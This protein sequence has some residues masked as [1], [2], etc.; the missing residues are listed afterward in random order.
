MVLIP[1]DAP[2]RQSHTALEDWGIGAGSFRGLS[3][4]KR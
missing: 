3:L 2:R 4:T 1:N